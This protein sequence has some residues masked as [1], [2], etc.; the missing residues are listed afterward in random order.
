MKYDETRTLSKF[1]EILDLVAPHTRELS[2]CEPPRTLSKFLEILT[3]VAPHTR[4]L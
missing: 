2:D 4:E 1:L 3:L